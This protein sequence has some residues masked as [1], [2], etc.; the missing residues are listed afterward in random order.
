MSETQEH[1]VTIRA[2]RE[3]TEK[4]AAATSTFE[5]PAYSILQSNN[6]TRIAET[7]KKLIQQFESHPNKESFLQDFNKTEEINTFSEKSEKLIADMK[8]TEIFELCE[9]PS[10]KQCTDC[11]LYW[12]IGIVYCTYGRC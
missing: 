10:K 3:V 8:S 5:Y 7:V 11:A 6:G 2:Y 1:L 12:E 9:T 4:P